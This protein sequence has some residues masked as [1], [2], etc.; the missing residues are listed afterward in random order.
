MEELTSFILYLEYGDGRFVQKLIIVYH[1]TLLSHPRRLLFI[2]SPSRA[3]ENSRLYVIVYLT[4]KFNQ[5]FSQCF[6]LVSFLL[7]SFY[8]G[9]S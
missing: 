3:T 2:V 8:V 6:L 1:T 9:R 5:I 4:V 7:L